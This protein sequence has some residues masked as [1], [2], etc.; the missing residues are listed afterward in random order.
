MSSRATDLATLEA[1]EGRAFALSVKEWCEDTLKA[2]ERGQDA[3]KLLRLIC[4]H[5]PAEAERHRQTMDAA[6]RVPDQLL[7]DWV[8][9]QTLPDWVKA[10]EAEGYVWDERAMHWRRV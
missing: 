10:M 7:T 6:R 8:K 2:L 4:K 1:H 5:L 9:H 3:E